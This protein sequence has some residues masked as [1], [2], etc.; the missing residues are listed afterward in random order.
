MISDAFGAGSDVSQKLGAGVQALQDRVSDERKAEQQQRAQIIKAAEDSGSTWEEVKAYA[1]GFAEA[2]VESTLNA[3]GTIL[4]TAAAAF[5]TRGNSLVAQLGA[6]APKVLGALQG[7]GAVKGGIYDAV[8]QQHKEAGLTPEEAAARAEQAQAYSGANAGHIALGAGLGLLAS[9]TGVEGAVGRM[10]GKA[11]AAGAAKNGLLKQAGLGV[12][13]ETPMEMAQGGQE[14]LASNVALQREDFD[15]PTWQGVAGQ[16]VQEGLASAPLGGGFGV[17]EGLKARREAARK[18][19]E[20]LGLNPDSGPIS[21]VAAAAVDEGRAAAPMQPEQAAQTE[22]GLSLAPEEQAQPQ[23]P[24][25][26]ER[27][28]VLPE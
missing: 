5:L 4:P 28:A 14:R 22:D 19:S 8:E 6:H 27:L 13:K 16:A 9:S 2:P 10:A 25:M 17:A 11:A 20:D 26:E 15:V 1:G 18:P 24:T 7:A 12:V 3:A 23:G 21:K